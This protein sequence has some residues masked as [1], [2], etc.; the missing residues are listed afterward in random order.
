MNHNRIHIPS[1]LID[2]LTKNWSTDLSQEL[3]QPSCQDWSISQLKALTLLTDRLQREIIAK[4][5]QS[6]YQVNYKD[7]ERGFDSYLLRQIKP[8]STL[9]ELGGIRF[10]YKHKNNHLISKNFVSWESFRDSNLHIQIDEVQQELILGVS[11]SLD[12][13]M[14]QASGETRERSKLG[15]YKTPLVLERGLFLD[16]RNQHFASMIQ[17]AKSNQWE[18]NL[19]QIPLS[20]TLDLNSLFAINQKP[21][22]KK[23]TSSKP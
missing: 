22:Q 6:E 21:G 20:F 7:F 18:K 13:S 9:R 17:L 11:S 4:K 1:W 3:L 10:Y 8:G 2:C 16:L 14:E 19:V 23:E 12:Y 15:S 5:N